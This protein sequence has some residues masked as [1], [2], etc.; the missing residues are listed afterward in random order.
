MRKYDAHE[1]RQQTDSKRNVLDAHTVDTMTPNGVKDD[2][3]L[4]CA[5]GEDYL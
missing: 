4:K 1:R 2:F 5:P 3:I